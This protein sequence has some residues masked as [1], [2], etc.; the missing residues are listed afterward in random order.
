LPGCH[1]IGTPSEWGS[2]N[3]AVPTAA[4]MATTGKLTFALPMRAD[5]DYS[6]DVEVPP[7]TGPTAPLSIHAHERDAS[8]KTTRTFA[9]ATSAQ[10]LESCGG[11]G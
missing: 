10:D 9:P 8:G 7:M 1:V 2:I 5:Y 6:V 4:V 3:G 11:E